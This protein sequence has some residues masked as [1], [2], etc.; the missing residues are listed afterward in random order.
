MV[1]LEQITA[2]A[3]TTFYKPGSENDA[4]RA[5]IAKKTVR[6]AADLGY[7]IVIVDGGSSDELLKEFQ[8]YGQNVYVHVEPKMGMGESRRHALNLAMKLGRHVIAWVEP[9]KENYIHSIAKTV[10][11]IFDGSADLVVPRRASLASYP[12]GQ[13]QAESMGNLFWN[14]LTGHDLDMWFGP[15]TFRR[16]ISAYFTTYNGEYGDKWDSIFIPV[17]DAIIGGENVKSVTVD[18]THPAEQTAFEEQDLSLY[19]KRVK[20]LENLLP[21]LETHWKKRK[22]I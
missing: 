18:Y 14:K 7:P 5:E 20:Q 17:M 1:N 3:T 21:A 10:E 22:G 9:E 15:R 11:P 19:L 13:Q 4:M 6:N 12:L 8:S 16:D 2:I